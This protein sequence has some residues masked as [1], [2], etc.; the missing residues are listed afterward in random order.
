MYF[1]EWAPNVMSRKGRM[2]SLKALAFLVEKTYDPGYSSIYWFKEED[3]KEILEK[4]SSTGLNK[5]EV[6]SKYLVLDL[7][8]GD[9]YLQTVKDCL[10]KQGL[11][12]EIWFSGSKGYHFYIPHA[13][14]CD[15]RLPYSHKL[16]VAELI[17]GAETIVDMSLYQHGRL[18]SLPGRVHPKTRK[19]KVF[20]EAKNGK[21]LELKLVTPPDFSSFKSALDDSLLARG[22]DKLVQLLI[23]A[24]SIGNRHTTIWATSKDLLASGLEYTT[25]LNLMQVVNSKWPNPKSEEEVEL[26]VK[27]AAK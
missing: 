8:D 26:A 3:A 13:L 12:Y 9:K 20:V 25:V 18:L 23:Q 24:P 27:Q 6:A 21:P 5:Y 10:D 19:K 15:I 22:L 11:A 7:D 16:A 17:P 14:L 2:V 4:E 1:V